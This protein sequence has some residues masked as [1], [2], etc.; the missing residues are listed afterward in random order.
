M[1]C[2]VSITR[3][4]HLAGLGTCSLVS[5]SATNLLFSLHIMA[6]N[7]TVS[8]GLFNSYTHFSHRLDIDQIEKNNIFVNNG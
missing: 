7:T 3:H 4:C 5:S 1:V 2:C 8:V 6:Q